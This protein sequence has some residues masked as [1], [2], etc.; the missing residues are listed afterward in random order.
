MIKEQN[1]ANTVTE[2]KQIPFNMTLAKRISDGSVQGRI[3]VVGDDG[4]DVGF[5]TFKSQ[6]GD[7]YNFF[8]ETLEGNTIL[9]FDN[10][11]LFN[12]G[13]SRCHLV[14]EI[15]T[16]NSVSEGSLW[17]VTETLTALQE[18]IR[19]GIW[20]KRCFE[21]IC[22]ELISLHERKNK[23]YGGAFDK[24]MLKYGVTALMIRLNDKWERLESLFKN[25]KAE[26]DDESF[27]DTLIDLA[28]YAIMGI[29]HLHN[30]ST[31]TK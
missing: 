14:L 23:D 6:R 16:N 8:V 31:K 2:F 12:S 24:S 18:L 28:S 17:T 29:E 7:N 30:I 22:C 1:N 13:V 26:V 25:G 20:D 21:S 3:K 11:G 15:P 19:N 9:S 5:A 10:I 27:E 4:S